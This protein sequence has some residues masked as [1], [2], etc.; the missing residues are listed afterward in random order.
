LPWVLRLFSP[1]VSFTERI[2]F[3]PQAS[4]SVYSWGFSQFSIT[5]PT[6]M[7]LQY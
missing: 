5:N 4:T 3:N 2:C 6:A 1:T 7:A